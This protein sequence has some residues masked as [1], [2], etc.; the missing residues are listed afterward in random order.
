MISP[1]PT[2]PPATQPPEE[3]KI[4]RTATTR[5]RPGQTPTALTIKAIFRPI[6]KVFYYIITAIKKYKL[7]TLGVIVLLLASIAAT[8][9]LTTG[10]LPLGIA[11]D[12][13]NFHINGGD[14]G[15]STVK[16]WLYALRSGNVTQLEYLD[17]NISSPPDVSTLVSTYS[18]AKSN[19][20]WKAIHVVGAYQESDTTVDS[21]IQVDLSADGPGG[22]T[23]GYLLWHFVTYTSGTNNILVEVALVDNRPNES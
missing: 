4:V 11:S 19:F 3:V 2:R 9:F 12:P 1:S 20:T 6:I 23:T 22:P 7:I 17:K 14:G 5:V 15:G 8:T 21:F 10:Q 13:F 18:Q 16:N